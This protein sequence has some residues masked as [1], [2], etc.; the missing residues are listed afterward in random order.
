M[1]KTISVDDDTHEAIKRMG[2]FG[3]TYGQIVKRIIEE[4]GQRAK[5]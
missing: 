3:E 5:K 4:K 2:K 1:M